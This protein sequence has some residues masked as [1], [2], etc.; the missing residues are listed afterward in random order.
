M[1]YKLGLLFSVA[2]ISIIGCKKGNDNPFDGLDHPGNI[3]EVD[4]TSPSSITG[5]QKNIFSVKCAI[6]SCHGGA[7]EPDFRSA[8]S[9]YSTL[10]YQHVKKNTLND[11]FRFR[12]IPYDTAGSWL[13][14][15]ITYND[16]LIAR[17]PLYALPLT[18]EEVTNINQWI[19]KGAPDVNGNIPTRIDENPKI[20]G[21][22]AYNSTNT[23]IDINRP[24][25]YEPFIA[26]ANELIKI[27]MYVDDK[28]TQEY[29]FQVNTLKLSL[30]QDDF[31]SAISVVATHENGPNF[32]GWLA[33]VNTGV[34]PAGSRV[35]MRYYV[36]DPNHT[37]LEERPVLQSYSYLKNYYSFIIQ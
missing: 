1:L 14:Q 22:A 28:E 33:K 2:T 7:F 30:K 13:H 16:T 9:S 19:L 32:W 37:E 8:Q 23:R 24:S 27:L 4:T 15:R 17:M 31:S 35:Y 18:E 11:E 25:Y 21:Y 5:L 34:F 26:P 3:T 36:K 6:P 20:F 29:Q 10:V 12:V